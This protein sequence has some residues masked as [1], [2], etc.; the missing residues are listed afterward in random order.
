MQVFA[1]W[2]QH[3]PALQKTLSQQG[4]PGP[5]HAVH[6]FVASLH[7]SPEA[8]Q[9]SAESRPPVGAPGQQS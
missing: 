3:P 5:P 1:F 2:S 7:E 9:K 4:W 8:V 6:F